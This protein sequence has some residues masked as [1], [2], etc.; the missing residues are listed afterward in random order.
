[1]EEDQ[2]REVMCSEDPEEEEV[3]AFLEY[4]KAEYGE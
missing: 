2:E 1:M 4:V 3:R